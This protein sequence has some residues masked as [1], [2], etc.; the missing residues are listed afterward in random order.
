MLGQAENVLGGMRARAPRAAIVGIAG[1]VLLPEEQAL[2]NAFPP[3]GVILFARNVRD[4][5]QLAA[6]VASLRAV[7]LPDADLM[8]DQEG[9]RVARLKPPHWHGH[10]P[11]AALGRLFGSNPLAGLRAA[12]LTGALIGH[13][14]RSAGFTVA[15]APVLDI[16]VPGAH[17]VIGD[18]AFA[19]H[20]VDVA[21]LGRAVANGLLGAGI[22]PVGK[23]APGHGRA[24]VDSH[25]LLPRVAEN[26]LS[27]DVR[28]FALNADLPWI[29]TAHI[30]YDALDPHVPATLS[31]TVIETV[32]RG[33]IGFKGVLV[34]DDL[35]MKALSGIPAELA[36]QALAA[37]C[38]VALYCSGDFA[39]TDALLRACPAL[40]PIAEQRLRTGRE[41]AANRRLTLQ[42]KLLSAERDR[43]LA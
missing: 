20:P 5:G 9:G 29:M 41:A 27:V 33:R 8:V 35:A 18:R 25:L 3:A 6:L 14:C 13:D 19:G 22:L 24:R 32:I 11:A 28:A 40:T 16:S 23:H 21:R 30:V 26:D 38:D 17:D 10:P 1:V 34:T 12:W 39:A 15:A 43:L 36:V 2:F 7:L 37:G 31:G 4:P 42:P